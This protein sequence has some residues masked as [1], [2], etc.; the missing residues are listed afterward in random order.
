[1]GVQFDIY[2]HKSC[3]YVNKID[4]QSI[5]LLLINKLLWVVELFEVLKPR[6]YLYQT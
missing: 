3:D 6:K 4:M 2:I 1:M 5:Y